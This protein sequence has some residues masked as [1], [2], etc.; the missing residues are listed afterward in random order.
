MGQ[1]FKQR[2]ASVYQNRI[3]RHFQFAERFYVDQHL[4][5]W[6]ILWKHW[7]RLEKYLSS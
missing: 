4:L 2:L 6:T 7:R 5:S 1:L 3:L